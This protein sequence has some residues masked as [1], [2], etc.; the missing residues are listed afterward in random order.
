MT[1][2]IHRQS[3]EE[4]LD[5]FFFATDAPA[6][7]AVLRACEAHPEFRQDI[8]EFA[9]LWTAHDASPEPAA[10]ELKVPATSVSRLQSYALNSLHEADHAGQA[11]SGIDAAKAALATLAGAGLR[12]AAAACGLGTATLL[13]N[14]ILNNLIVD[15]PRAVLAG[16][17]NH[18]RVAL[19]DLQ[20]ALPGRLATGTHRS[21]SQKPSTPTQET[22][23]DAVG[24]MAGVSDSEKARLMALANEE[25]KS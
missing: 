10:A 25:P 18:L 8:L 21:A 3:L 14:K 20:V 2:N 6:A 23:A 9:A 24:S 11:G 16:L 12:R 22:W 15:A 17:A 13:L 7:T 4:V 5:E 19:S 1:P